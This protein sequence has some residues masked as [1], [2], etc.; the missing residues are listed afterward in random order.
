MEDVIGGRTS[1][2]MSNIGD[3]IIYDPAKDTW[4]SAAPMPTPRSRACP[5]FAEYHGMLFVAGGECKMGKPSI[6]SKPTTPRT[7]AG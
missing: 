6:M 5:A 1:T 3:H 2:A 4:T 7:I